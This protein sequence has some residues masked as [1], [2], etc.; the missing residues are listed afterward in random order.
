[1]VM[2]IVIVV[3]MVVIV[4]MMVMVMMTMMLVIMFVMM[5]VVTA[6]VVFVFMIMVTAMVVFMHILGSLF[7]PVHR[8]RHV[9]PP[10]AAPRNRLRPHR[11]ILQSERVHFFEIR[12]TLRIIEQL[13]QRRIQHVT[14]GT[15]AAID[16]QTPHDTLPPV[17][18]IID[19]RYPAPNPLSML[20][21]ETPDAQELSIDSNA[22]NPPNDAP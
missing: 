18:L 5:I 2:M 13:V 20:T 15:H 17:W 1:M 22:D 12:G 16:I 3:M 9:R 10:N 21:T 11:N 6:M 14:R 19:A 4:V 8:H 7:L